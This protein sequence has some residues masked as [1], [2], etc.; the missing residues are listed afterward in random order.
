[1]YYSLIYLPLAD[2]TVLTFISPVLGCWL[3]AHILKEPFGTREKL[4]ALVSFVGVVFIAQP[5]AIFDHNKSSSIPT[6]GIIVTRALQNATTHI[7]PSESEGRV[8][9][10]RQKGIAIAVA[11]LGCLGGT[12]VITA[13]RWIGRRAHPL[14]SVNYFA[15][16]ATIVSGVAILLIPSIGGFTAPKTLKEWS[17][18]VFLGKSPSEMFRVR[19]SYRSLANV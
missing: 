9:T 1:M 5:S 18:L 3:C 17:L 13:L 7:V 8:I 12:V 16:C 10:S 14:I 15:T 11:L 2:A 4:A 6:A 19:F